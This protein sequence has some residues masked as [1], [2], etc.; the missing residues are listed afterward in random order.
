MEDVVYERKT[1]NLVALISFMEAL[2]KQRAS[3]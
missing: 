3:W 2:K 1:E